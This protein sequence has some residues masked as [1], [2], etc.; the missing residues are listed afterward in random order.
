ME[1]VLKEKCMNV[2]YV[3]NP[4]LHQLI[5][6]DGISD[7]FRSINTA[8]N[9]IRDAYESM[10]ESLEV[11]RDSG[12]S[13]TF[14]LKFNGEVISDSVSFGRSIK[15]SCWRFI[16]TKLKVTEVMSYARWSEFQEIFYENDRSN[17]IDKLPDITPANILD[18][19]AAY[20]SSVVEFFKESV[21]EEWLYWTPKRDTYVAN[22]DRWKV[23]QKIIVTH[24]RDRCSDEKFVANSV[25]DRHCRNLGLIFQILDGVSI[26]DAKKDLT[27]LFNWKPFGTYK[28]DYFEVRTFKN[29]NV[30]L[31]VKRKDLLDKFNQLGVGEDCGL[32]NPAGREYAQVV[33]PFDDIPKDKVS[34]FANEPFDFYPTPKLVVE[35]MY[36]HVAA[37]C[38]GRKDLTLL[39]PSVGDGSL[40]DYARACDVGISRVVA[41]ELEPER[42]CRAGK[43]IES[44]WY[45][46]DSYCE[47]RDFLL[48]EPMPFADVVLMNPPF[49]SFRYVYHVVHAAKFLR[50]NGILVAVIPPT[51]LNSSS[52]IL[53]KFKGWVEKQDDWTWQPNPDKAF[54]GSGTNVA[55]G[56]LT[57]LRCGVVKEVGQRFEGISANT[58]H[59]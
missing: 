33:D 16:L 18:V 3:D 25:F 41:M 23:S 20:S 37:A 6:S 8:Y 50:Q 39:E 9:Q 44:H 42:A 26:K 17:K 14:E 52:G 29:G 31:K 56:I 4:D 30:H 19:V 35:M 11:L 53:N 32:P 27:N 49:G 21:R 24:V 36:D 57:I 54:G 22:Q 58:T 40:L 48:A 43:I 1:P 55:T 15:R 7:E 28:N 2:Q 10:S 46:Y 51:W 59:Q 38:R 12:V 47:C 5:V 13:N 34:K 45:A